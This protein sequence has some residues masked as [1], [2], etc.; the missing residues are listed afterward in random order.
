MR[1]FFKRTNPQPSLTDARCAEAKRYL[2]AN[3]GFDIDEFFGE[4][5]VDTLLDEPLGSSAECLSANQIARIVEEHLIPA[6]RQIHLYECKECRM[7]VETYQAICNTSTA[8]ENPLGD[9]TIDRKG[10]L[11]IPQ[12]GPFYLTLINHGPH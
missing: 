4:L 2:D 1:N 10:A 3:I 11:R 6:A 8:A 12:R 7:A 5:D 9:I